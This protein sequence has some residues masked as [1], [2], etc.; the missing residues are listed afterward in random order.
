MKSKS[1]NFRPR[2]LL[3]QRAPLVQRRDSQAPAQIRSSGGEGLGLATGHWGPFCP[4]SFL[5]SAGTQVRPSL[6]AAA[7][8][9]GG[10]DAPNYKCPRAVRLLIV[11]CY[12]AF[13]PVIISI[14]HGGY[15]LQVTGRNN[16]WRTICK[17]PTSCCTSHPQNHTNKHI[18]PTPF[19]TRPFA[20]LLTIFMYLPT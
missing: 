1:S 9:W 3:L 14:V 5:E 13:L 19:L 16:S 12:H 7:S 17:I 18:P 2:T 15:S 10:A 4:C 6:G 8:S 11:Q 20:C